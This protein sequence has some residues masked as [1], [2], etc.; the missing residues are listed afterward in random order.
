MEIHYHVMETH[1]PLM[2]TYNDLW[3]PFLKNEELS[4]M[5]TIVDNKACLS[6]T[7]SVICVLFA[8]NSSKKFFDFGCP[9]ID[10]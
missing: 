7:N 4:F 10:P 5:E 8:Q 2:E 6:K 3:K 1:N 9:T